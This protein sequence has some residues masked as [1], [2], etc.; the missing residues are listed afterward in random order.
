MTTKQFTTGEAAKRVGIS[1]V[2]LQAWIAAKKIRPPKR[3]AV[4]N[5][6]VRMWSQADLKML[7]T[8]KGKIYM[9]KGRGPK[10]K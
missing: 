6:V 8:A 10:A 4:G 5:I 3:T 7:R 2:T 1:R 9:K